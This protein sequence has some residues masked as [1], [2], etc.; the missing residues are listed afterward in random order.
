V[1]R[2]GLPRDPDDLAI[3]NAII[4]MGKALKLQ[5][6]AEGV[7]TQA[8]LEVL[9]SPGCDEIQGYLVAKP[10]PG[11]DLAQVMLKQG[12]HWNV[13]AEGERSLRVVG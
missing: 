12:S 6:I 1:I 11:A 4:A 7:E 2:R 13:R 8:Q 3:S 9:Q 10:M 5:V